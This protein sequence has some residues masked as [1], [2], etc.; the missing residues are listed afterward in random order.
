MTPRRARLP[1]AARHGIRPPGV[2]QGRDDRRAHPRPGVAPT[3]T[4]GTRSP[5]RSAS[6]RRSRFVER[7]VWIAVAHGLHA[8]RRAITAPNSHDRPGR[9]PA[10]RLRG[11]RGR[12]PRSGRRAARVAA[13]AFSP[14]GDGSEDALRLRWTNGVR[15]GLA[16][17][18][19]AAPRRQRSSGH[20]G[21]PR[22]A[23]PVRAGVDVG[24]QGRRHARARTGRTCCSSS[25][26][27]AA[28]TY[29]RAVGAARHA[30]DQLARY[31]V[32]IDTVAP[33]GSPSASGTNQVI[34][35]NGDGV[36]DSTTPQARGDRRRRALDRAGDQRVGA[37]VRTQAGT[38][39]SV[40][41]HLERHGRRAAAAS[42]D[43]RYA[44]A[45]TLFDAAGNA[46]RRTAMLVVDTTAPGVDAGRRRRAPS[47]PT[48]TAQL[49][50]T[51]LSWTAPRARDAARARL[52]K[53]ST[54]DPA[55][56]R[57]TNVAGWKATWNGT[58]ADGS[59][60]SA[61]GPTRSRSTSRT[62]PAT[63]ASASTKRVVVD[64][65]V[66]GLAW[67]GDLFPQ[68]G[69]ALKATSRLALA[70]R[71]RREGDAP[72]HNAGGRVVRTAWSGQ[73][74]ARRHAVLDVERRRRRRVVRARR[75][76]TSRR[77]G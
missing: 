19:R 70:A 12:R 77:C 76:A 56:G 51:V 4:P 64:R 25:G 13:R 15:H 49:D 18:Q 73:S 21:R 75:A 17:A 2:D 37:T 61:T 29:P 6:G 65:T 58:R 32:R 35:P 63:G 16:D 42:P 39:A 44:V 28:A 48:A 46:A 22:P 11:D 36:R 57:S 38:G 7:G 47:R 71:P 8:A 34:S 20:A 74:L 41:V 10:A 30:P 24:R 72:C 31:G 14:N 52:Y 67:S 23:R 59:R 40:I 45:L 33:D 62:R 53:G 5:S 55:P 54:L 9:D 26:R 27:R 68:D 50:T 1:G 66:K 43:G 3:A 60:A 69:D